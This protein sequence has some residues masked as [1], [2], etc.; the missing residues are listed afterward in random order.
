MILYFSTL[1]YL[2]NR[3]SKD[4]SQKHAGIL[5]SSMITSRGLIQESM[6]SYREVY[7]SQNVKNIVKSSSDQLI[8]SIDSRAKLSWLTL[9][10]KYILDACVIIGIIFVGGLASIISTRENAITLCVLFLVSASRLVPSLLRL[11]T[12]FQGINDCS[13]ASE[14][15]Y[16]FLNELEYSEMS[17]FDI[18][19]TTSHKFKKNIALE[20]NGLKFTYPKSNVQVLSDL[21]FEINYGEF[22][23]IVG[24]SGS[25]KSTLADLLMGVIDDPTFSIRISGL[26]PRK[27][28]EKSPGIINYV[29]QRVALISGTIRE[30]VALGVRVTEID[31]K[32]ISNAL[33]KASIADFV[34]SLPEG[35]NTVVGENGYNL[36][37]GQAQRI[38]LARALYTNPE[39]L[40]LDEAT[41]ALD[42]ET[43]N[44]ISESLHQLAG[45]ITL[46]VI[47]HRLATVRQAN[48]I[49]YLG[50]GNYFQL[51]TFDELRER[52]PKFDKQAKLLGL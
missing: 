6:I 43:E 3:Y 10:P 21:S 38:G 36:S 19:D 5:N 28:V 42:S 52:I 25:G 20:V 2:L 9:L 37:G 45:N 15:F 8:K 44:A 30:N 33:E 14:R 27:R 13:D 31:E 32:S 18:P 29:P 4:F 50:E 49:L 51:G 46:I 22:L 47:A 35:L 1:V 11:N 16:T 23:A 7:V 41:S 17:K 48:K 26:S 24:P 34:R 39:I 12:G 40:I